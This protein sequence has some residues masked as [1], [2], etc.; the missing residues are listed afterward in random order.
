MAAVKMHK[1]EL[2]DEAK[3]DEADPMKLPDDPM[4][5]AADSEEEKDEKEKDKTYA[6]SI[7]LAA[8]QKQVAELQKSMP[9][10]RSS[11]EYDALAAAQFKAEKHYSAFGDSLA[12]C[13]PMDGE[14]VLAYRKRMAKGLQ[15][16]SAKWGKVNIA[17]ADASLL[18]II[19]E[20][21][22]ADSMSAAMQPVTS[23]GGFPRAIVTNEGGRTR[24]EYVGGTPLSV[25]APFRMTPR[26]LAAVREHPKH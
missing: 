25:F 24:T 8:L 7:K 21:I 9:K 6:D 12:K 15:K 5:T 20:G 11:D 18:D 26:Q 4:Q 19:E 17:A 10:Q 2:G 22:Y 3:K 1:S 14:S 23:D 13:R 16:H